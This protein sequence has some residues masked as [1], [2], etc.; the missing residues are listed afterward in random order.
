MCFYA[1]REILALMMSSRST[2]VSKNIVATPNTGSAPGDN[3]V[4]V[5]KSD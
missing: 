2:R 4:V 5:D 1:F 3:I